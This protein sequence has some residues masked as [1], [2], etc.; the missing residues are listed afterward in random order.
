MRF[1]T[2]AL[3]VSLSLAGPAH[4]INIISSND[5]GWAEVN[6]RALYEALTSA[7][8]V[9]VVSAP[10]ED[11]SGTGSDQG[12]PTVLTE[13]C[14]FDSCPAGSP[15]IGYNAS[16]PR[17]NYV[18]SYPA[19]SMKYGINSIGPKHFDGDAPDLAVTGPNV[20]YN[21]GIE[22]FLSGTVGAATY[23]AYN[24][25]IPAIA[26]SGSTGSQTAWNASSTFPTYSQIYADLAM[27]V[28][29]TLI[30]SGTPYLPDNIWLN[31]NFPSVSDT[32]CT[33]TDDFKFVLSR[34]HIAVPLITADD[35]TTCG[36]SRLP[37][38][39][40]VALTSGCYASISVGTASDKLDANATMQ[41]VV[42][43]KLSG[44]LSCL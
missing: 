29:D 15:A 36:S 38:E 28:T 43:N 26:F 6:I 34:I 11:E 23:A 8:H 3:L 16:Q 17:L 12:T 14:E 10:A 44:I 18:N 42:L 33:S 1:N 32:E 30:A 7:G 5:D 9:T 20:G 41:E 31:V 40:K 35:V 21:I 24:A 4:A 39:Y 2:A 37:T 19:T 22:A 25:G 27:N 13:A